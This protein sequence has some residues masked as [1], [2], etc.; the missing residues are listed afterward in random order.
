MVSLF[1]YQNKRWFWRVNYYIKNIKFNFLKIF[2]RQKEGIKQV[3]TGFSLFIELIKIIAIDFLISIII[4]VILE[5]LETYILKI[6]VNNKPAATT[7]LLNLFSI[8]HKGVIKSAPTI[9]TLFTVVA[10]ISGIFLGLYFTAISVVMSSVFVKVPSNLRELLLKEKFGNQ[11]IKILAI[12]ASSSV[13]LLS[14]IALGKYPGFLNLLY[15]SLMGCFGI[16]GIIK[17]GI[18]TFIFL[19]PTHLSDILFFDLNSNIRYSTIYGYRWQDTNFQAHYNKIA[20]NNILTLSTIIN[21][22]SKEQHLQKQP[23]SNILKKSIYFLYNYQQQK[24][25]IPSDSRW[26]SLTPKYKNWFFEDYSALTTALKTQTS[27]QPELIPN[28][29]WLEDNLMEIIKSP[30][31]KILS[32]NNIETAY[33]ILNTFILYL[34]K[35][36]ENLEFKKGKEIINSLGIII[37]NY[38]NKNAIAKNN[39]SNNNLAIFDIYE[40]LTLSLILGFYKTVRNLDDKAILKKI[41]SI[42]WNNIKGLYKRQFIP[43]IL[44]TLEFI[45]KCLKFEELAERRILSPNW[46]LRQLIIIRYLDLLQ[47]AT[48]E[49]MLILKEFFISKS[50]SLISVKSYILVAHHTQRGLEMCDKIQAI[51]SSLEK[52]TKDFEKFRIIKELSWQT[53][54]WKQINDNIIESSDILMENLAKCIPAISAIEQKENTPDIFGQAYNTVCQGC[55]DSIYFKK[56]ERF[57]KLFPLFFYSALLAF[58]KLEQKLKDWRPETSLP[59]KLEPLFD[60]IEL[61]GYSKIYSELFEIPSI[62]SVCENTWNL[63]LQNKKAPNEIIKFLVESY[64]YYKSLF[65]ISTRDLLRTNWKISFNHVLLEM[66]LIDG[67]VPFRR[68]F[69]N[70]QK[71][72]H[73]SALIRALCRGR[74]EPFISATDVFILIYLLKRPESKEI[75]YKDRYHLINSLS[76]E[77]TDNNEEDFDE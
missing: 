59:I 24:S 51:F 65:Q 23:L 45:Q 71:F 41:D 32:K 68:Y 22:C 1:K 29:Y 17:L 36:G 13:L 70:K 49:T 72:K 74:Y 48:N 21:L 64:K 62:W 5:I 4:I 57:K 27:I 9:G 28:P 43:N 16:F 55:Y 73:K 20:A 33:E 30:I 50:E 53:W 14:Y 69:N 19:D 42:N 7:Y 58:D 10:S 52:I 40:L 47:D 18:R 31:E 15:I 60:I 56:P 54:N 61:S 6:P 67:R 26:Y 76:K 66:N 35:L 75:D 37:E 3:K 44:P 63:Y 46:Y 38:I 34:G 39:Y 12:I 8:M 25:F 2:F 77:E 11:F